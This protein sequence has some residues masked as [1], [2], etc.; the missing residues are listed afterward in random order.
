MDVL[1]RINFL[2]ECEELPNAEDEQGCYLELPDGLRLIFHE[3]K[4]VGWYSGC[5]E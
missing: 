3:G 2:K 5:C 4:Y 1:W